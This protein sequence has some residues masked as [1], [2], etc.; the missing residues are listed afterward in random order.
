MADPSL[1][2]DQGRTHW[3]ARPIVIAIADTSKTACL[4]VDRL[5]HRPDLAG[6]ARIWPKSASWWP[7]SRP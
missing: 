7:V 4:T 3:P 5:Q 6:L 1:A 2:L